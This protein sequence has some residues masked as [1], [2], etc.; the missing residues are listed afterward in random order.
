MSTNGVLLYH[1]PRDAGIAAALENLALLAVTAFDNDE[2]R[3]VTPAAFWWDGV[4]EVTQ[5]SNVDPDT[6]QIDIYMSGEFEE[7]YSRLLTRP[8]D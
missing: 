5:V 8:A 3:R 6:E 2:R 1:V 4:D 7:M